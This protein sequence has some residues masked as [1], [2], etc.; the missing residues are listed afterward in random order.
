MTQ[1][2]PDTAKYRPNTS[3]IHLPGEKR[4][5]NRACG[6][7]FRACGAIFASGGACGGPA[8]LKKG[9]PNPRHMISSCEHKPRGFETSEHLR[10]CLPQVF[11]GPRA[12]CRA[13]S[14]RAASCAPSPRTRAATSNRGLVM[15]PRLVPKL[16]LQPSQ[17]RAYFHEH[18]RLPG[19]VLGRIAWLRGGRV[20]LEAAQTYQRAEMLLP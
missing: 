1:S 19:L 15:V 4:H 12:P 5:E 10:I 11:P 8:S 17:M 7:N 18:R 16:P 13:D 3:P 9:T 20:R 14:L 2:W 6:A